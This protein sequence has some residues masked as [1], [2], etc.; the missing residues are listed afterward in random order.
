[1]VFGF[2]VFLIGES[3][4]EA[5]REFVPEPEIPVAFPWFSSAGTMGL[6]PGKAGAGPKGVLGGGVGVGLF[7]DCAFSRN[8]FGERFSAVALKFVSVSGNSAES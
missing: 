1:M 2:N 5:T 7:D 4:V 8:N 3:P 6:Q